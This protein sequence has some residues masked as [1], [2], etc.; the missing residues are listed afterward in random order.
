MIKGRPVYYDM[1]DKPLKGDKA[2]LTWAKQYELSDKD[3]VV[4]QQT[5]WLGFYVSTVWLGID[6]NFL[7]EG[8]PLIYETM[9]F[10][11]GCTDLDCERYST[12]REAKIGHEEM[13]KKWSTPFYVIRRLISINSIFLWRVKL[14]IKEKLKKLLH[15]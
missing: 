2:V 7:S 3:R 15:R 8:P 10:F 13:V 6:H 11:R 1:N 4:K 5:T 9:I 14:W 12:R